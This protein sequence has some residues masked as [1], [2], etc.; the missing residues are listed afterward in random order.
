MWTMLSTANV[1]EDPK[2]KQESLFLALSGIDLPQ[3]PRFYVP[4]ASIAKDAAA[5]AQPIA[6]LRSLNPKDAADIDATV[7]KSGREE[8][9]LGFIPAS[10]P[11]RDF[12]VVVDRST[13]AIVDKLMLKPW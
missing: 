2:L 12:A 3:Q 4:Y 8:A 11:N 10:A 1:P 9:A 5:R 13:G 7:R 6:A